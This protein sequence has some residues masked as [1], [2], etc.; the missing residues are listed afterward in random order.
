MT[1]ELQPVAQRMDRR[2]WVVLIAALLTVALTLRLGYWQLDR[3]TQKKVLQAS[4]DARGGMPPLPQSELSADPVR[5][6]AHQHRSVR[7]RGEW[8]PEAT[9]FLDN[10]QMNARPGF[11]V[12]T[13]LRLQDGLTLLPSAPRLIWVQRGWAPRDNNERTRLP[14]VPT[15]QGTVE[16][17]GRVAPAPARLY[18]FAAD[19]S[20]PIRQNLDVPASGRALGQPVLPLTVVQTEAPPTGPDG[21][22]RDWP[23]PVVDVQKHLGYAFQWFALC[24]LVAGLYVWFQL[25][26]P[27]RRRA[28]QD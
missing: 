22:A 18:E 11:F 2:A 28:P 4:F 13:P 19:A 8:L 5:A 10:R 26:R 16:V 1:A 24:A 3:A 23:R 6:A 14:A 21:L 7:L 20:G 25:I 15:P 9:V 17:V 12:M 27:R